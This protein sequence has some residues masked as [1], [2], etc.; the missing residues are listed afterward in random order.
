MR[1]PSFHSSSSARSRPPTAKTSPAFCAATSRWTERRAGP[2]IN[3]LAHCLI[4][5]LALEETHPDLVAGGFLGEFVKGRV[6]ESL[7]DTLATG[8]RLHRRIDAYSNTQPAI[9][10]SCQ[11]FPA[12]LRRFAPVFVDIIADHLLAQN[13]S[14]YHPGA[15]AEFSAASYRAIAAREA[16]LPEPGRRLFE[17]MLEADLL[18]S[19]ADAAV[20]YRALGSVARRL[21]RE[22]LADRLRE[23]VPALLPELQADFFDYFPDLVSHAG[24]WLSA[25][26]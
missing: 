13:W 9:R 10:A 7:P 14:S 22:E 3:F 11:R 18:A 12:P 21:R 2:G 23:T 17:F 19:Y 4:P 6:P 16:L 8:V 5:E 20:M 24:Q 25:E 26:R 15:I 1:R